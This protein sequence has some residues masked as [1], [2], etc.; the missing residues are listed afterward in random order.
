MPAFLRA[1]LFFVYTYARILSVLLANHIG[2]G[3]AKVPPAPG[4]IG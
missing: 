3:R 1:F 2:I 4:E